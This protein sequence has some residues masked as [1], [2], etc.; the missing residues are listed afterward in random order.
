MNDPLS[1]FRNFM[2][3][4]VPG[5]TPGRS[6]KEFDIAR[7][8]LAAGIRAILSLILIL[9]AL[10]VGK[11]N[12]QERIARYCYQTCFETLH[13]AE[14][15]LREKAGP[16]G[17]LWRKRETR[18]Y[19]N[20]ASGPILMI[21]YT[22][23]DH[24]PSVLYK[25][26]Y[27][28]GGWNSVQG[29]C[30]PEVDPYNATKCGDEQ[31]A[32]VAMMAEF[33]STWHT[34]TLVDEGYE[35]SYGSPYVSVRRTN[36]YGSI[37]FTSV[38]AGSEQR[39][40]NYT[41]WCPGWGNGNEPPAKRYIS[42]AKMQHFD[43]PA[44]FQPKHADNPAYVP[45]GLA[46]SWP[47]LCEPTMP[48]QAIYIYNS[49]QTE[50]APSNCN[51]CFP[52]T[53]DKARFEV[54]FQFAGRDFVR[55]YHSLGQIQISPDLGANWS[56]TYA[57]VLTTTLGT[58]RFTERGYLETYQSG[59]GDQAAGETLTKLP[60]GELELIEASGATR[61]FDAQG[62][63]IAVGDPL[64]QNSVTLVYDSSGRL[65]RAADGLGRA[66]LFGYK[67]SK[68]TSI[69]LPDGSSATYTYDEFDNLTGV[70]RPDGSSRQYLYAEPGLAPSQGRN[71]LTGIAEGS[72]RYA[73]FSY[74]EKAKVIGSHLWSAGQPVDAITISYNADGSATT[75]NSLGEVRQNLVGGENF[76]QITQTAD[77]RGVTSF[78]FS[79]RGRKTYTQDAL[80]NRV[81][82][83]YADS[84][85]G[86]VSQV[87]TTTEES[88]GR[89]TR[90]IRDS[91]NRV[92]E[93]RVSQM[94]GGG[95]QLVSL[96]RE[97]P[98]ALGR[99]LFSCKY[100]AS[101][102]TDYV[103]GSLPTAPAN[104]RQ[105]AN[106]YCT[107][108]DVAANSALCPIAGLQR[109]TKDPAGNQ[110]RFEYYAANDA[111]CDAKGA[112]TYR[113]G[114]LRAVINALGQR[115]ELLEY[116]AF[117]NA[118]QI[119]G[120]DGVVVERLFD[121]GGRVLS[122]TVK[123][124]VPANDRISLNEYS[125]TGKR[126]RTTGPDGVWTHTLYDTADRLVA[127]E[128]E[129]GNRIAYTLDAAGNRI[130]EE[131]RDGSGALKRYMER[132]F[133]TAS[134]MTSQASASG[135]V[136][137]YRHDANG[138]VL[139][140]E[141]P[142]GLISRSTYDGE[143]RP[144][145]QIHDPG[146]INAEVRYGY[147]ANGQIEQVVD[148]KGLTTHYAYDGFGSQ[149]GQ[150]SPDTGS[151]SFTLDA[152][153]KRKAHTDARGVTATYSYDALE[154]LTGIAYPDPNLD[155]VYIYD[156]APSTCAIA[157][158]FAEGRVGQVQHA[159]GNTVYCYDR[160]GQVARKVQT[161]NGVS[162][163]LQ[164]AYTKSGS[165]AQLIY[166]DGSVADYVHDSLGRTSEIG[167]TLP[168]K[169]R[170]V[171]V[172]NITYAPFG[173]A[174]SWT[175]GN[176][177]H[178]LRELDKDYRP[179]RVHDPAPGGLSIALEYDADGRIV[180]LKD[181]TESRK[182]AQYGY[183]AMGRLT[184]TKDGVT[185]TP[186]ETYSYDATGNRISMT[187]SA[188]TATYTYPAD[189]HHLTEVNGQARSYDATGNTLS[190]GSRRYAHGD[191]N[192]MED[193]TQGGVVLESYTYNHRGQRILRRPSSGSAEVTLYDESN[194]WIGSYRGQGEVI[195]QAIWLDDYPIAL[196]SSQTAG[197][198][199]LVYV[200]PDHLG[201]PRVVIDPVRDVVI[202]EWSNTSEAFGNQVPNSDPDGDG[203]AYE[204]AMRF[205]G[206]QATDVSGL[207][208]NNQRDYD[209]GVGRYI[210]SDPL[211]LAAGTSTYLYV[212]ADPLAGT[213]VLGLGDRQLGDHKNGKWLE[214]G[215]GCSI[216]IDFRLDMKTR[217]RV[218]HLHWKCR[219]GDEGA[220]G[221]NGEKSH[222]STWQDVPRHIREC[223]L[224]KGF[225]GAPAPTSSPAPRFE[226]LEQTAGS[227]AA[228]TS[229]ALIILGAFLLWFVGG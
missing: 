222:G 169:T 130:R 48:A 68:L 30:A 71:L 15:E 119:R 211:G 188:G 40:Y 125:S 225:N 194:H 126:T 23:D 167:L 45:G 28:V 217:E 185:G 178:L 19:M 186:I 82:Y 25:P 9:T 105:T 83:A 175:Y 228:T 66:L 127:I 128:D 2:R 199:N 108:A 143:G 36:G 173:P 124:D 3:P 131:V 4:V 67:G 14:A 181:G 198:T 61:R 190:I 184:H 50:S 113:K 151:E 123:G 215:R 32:V 107:D 59:R 75:V 144:K 115:T 97:V 20:S 170:Q 133:D 89:V 12:A 63:L 62:R 134:R 122:E 29:I 195:Q 138:N 26:G 74:N 145:V 200:Q 102:S 156:V 135:H 191:S 70:V 47:L 7:I 206:Q 99:L 158:R 142:M 210:Q 18:Q 92:V 180:E 204:L 164:Y 177:R 51:P 72:E 162:A 5:L 55:S 110:F 226:S 87:L 201:T 84:S 120:I 49:T 207:V 179:K 163:T 60:S 58:G 90:T 69:T 132:Q 155:V 100:D 24:A 212:S 150:L 161:V 165:L 86:A 176:G 33:R 182:L 139:E 46:L 193:V 136:V 153:G 205:P 147:A 80:G 96:N 202:W 76:R 53:G 91:S 44:G 159:G 213:D 118:I 56:H 81:S 41:V 6:L 197:V 11:A 157:E 57:G 114:D 13:E 35:G 223:A 219:N 220:C 149:Q 224:R 43:C 227:K 64:P 112:C 39:K 95:E 52:A 117:G 1:A 73:T 214:C 192:R 93:E 103:C 221:E 229:G 148:P 171:L 183:D 94:I 209:P 16:Y 22:V 38:L 174:A 109:F 152:V 98:D 104:V 168:G 141:S 208:Y 78:G 187:T 10:F 129:T 21:R 172:T 111:G 77:S 140:T 116:D 216:K 101:Q 154:R 65:E 218:Y 37:S 106:I 79:S 34:C 42:L 137:L 189:S 31:K 121:S 54:D 88:L 203:V 160:F 166:P 85:S 17:R 196:V 8:D 27:V 146:G